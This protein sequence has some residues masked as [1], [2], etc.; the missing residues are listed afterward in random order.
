MLFPDAAL[1]TQKQNT[2]EVI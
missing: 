1:S 2:G